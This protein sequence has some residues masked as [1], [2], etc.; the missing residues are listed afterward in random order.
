MLSN[1][2]CTMGKITRIT[3]Y[4]LNHKVPKK[5]KNLRYETKLKF[6]IMPPATIEFGVY[7][8]VLGSSWHFVYSSSFGD[9]LIYW[10]AAHPTQRTS[11]VVMNKFHGSNPF[12]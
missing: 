9:M 8:L 4:I 12:L 5:K 1:L 3:W 6:T 10:L 11:T 7:T 2:H